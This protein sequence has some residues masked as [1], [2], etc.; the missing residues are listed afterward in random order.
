MTERIEVLHTD[1]GA[2]SGVGVTLSS[3]V[4]C[5]GDKV[6]KGFSRRS[7]SLCQLWTRQAVA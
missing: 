1:K 5:I 2:K 6:I 3:K 4:Q 7:N